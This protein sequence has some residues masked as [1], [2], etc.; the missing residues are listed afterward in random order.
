ML[1]SVYWDAL[2]ST[3]FMHTQQLSAIHGVAIRKL[4]LIPDPNAIASFQ[5]LAGM[6]AWIHAW[7]RKRSKTHDAQTTRVATPALKR[8]SRVPRADTGRDIALR[9]GRLAESR[10]IPD[11]LWR[12]NSAHVE[13]VLLNPALHTRKREREIHLRLAHIHAGI[14][15]AVE[16]ARGWLNLRQLPPRGAARV[17]RQSA[18]IAS[19]ETVAQERRRR[20]E[21]GIAEHTAPANKCERSIF[22]FFLLLLSFLFCSVPHPCNMLKTECA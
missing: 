20:R 11:A 19:R 3:L 10:K 21:P 4:F 8:S 1:M 5:M 22:V 16:W 14:E 6:N 2:L 13:K 7:K 18:A 12:G 15:G 9:D 17:P